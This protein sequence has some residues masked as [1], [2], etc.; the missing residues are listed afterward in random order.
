MAAL[1]MDIDEKSL[2]AKNAALVSVT[3][4][5]PPFSRPGNRVDVTVSSLG[6][7]RS[8]SGGTLLATPLRD[9]E[10]R[11]IWAI[12]QGSLAIGGFS[13]SG[14][15]GSSGKNHT[16]TARVP[17]GGKVIREIASNLLDRDVIRLSLRDADFKTA[18]SVGRV[19]NAQLLGDFAHALD[20]G[21]IE[22]RVPPQYLG[23]VPELVAR[24]E[25]AEIEPDQAARVVVNERTGTVVMGSKVRIATVAV[26]HGGLTLEVDT[27]LG[28]SQP[29]AFS[30]GTT[31]VTPETNIDVREEEGKLEVL[32]GASIGEVVGAL[33]QMGVS[34]RD[35]ISILQAVR[36]AGALDAE[37]EVL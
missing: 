19:I 37:L 11:I 16:T 6:D 30:G 14:G 12:A 13:A 31:V 2:K 8:L 7:A 1:E 24:I 4:T 25:S 29:G 27:K 17:S 35:L 9:V 28:V 34:P 5:L 36:A 20:A 26:A 15:G 33:N 32:G 23:R 10:G 3:A 22:L 18:V 21:T